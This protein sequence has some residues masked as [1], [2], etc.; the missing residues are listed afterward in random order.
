MKTTTINNINYTV[1]NPNTKRASQIINSMKYSLDWYHLYDRPSVTKEHIR[2]YWDRE[3]DI[4]NAHIVGYT[5]N[6]MTFSIYAENDEYYFYIT[7]SYNYAVPK[8]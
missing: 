4:I 2:N 5:G 7:K 3:L 8:N 1:I 6:S